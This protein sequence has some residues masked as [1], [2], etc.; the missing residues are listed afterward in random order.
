[1]TKAKGALIVKRAKVPRPQGG[2][3]IH[4][5]AVFH[6][7]LHHER[8]RS[9]RDGSEF[10]LVVLDVT[11][12][13]SNGRGIQQVARTIKEKMRSIDEVGWL[14][15]GNIGIL[16]PVTKNEGGRRFANRLCESIPTPPSSIPWMVYTYPAHWLPGS[17]ADIGAESGG[18]GH[19]DEKAIGNVF[20]KRVPVWK[21]SIDFIGSLILLFLF[22]P[23]FLLLVLYI[24]A[25]SPGKSFFRQQ[26]VGYRGKH[27]TFMKFRTMR[28]NT[29]ADAHRQYWKGLIK[30][31]KPMEK[32]DCGRDPRI[33]PGGKIIRKACLDELPQLF[34]VLRGDMSL[35][36]PRPCI[37]YEA[38]EYLRWHRH[39]FDILPGM[40]GLWQVSGKNK[41]SFEQ[42]VRLDISYAN[43]MSPLLD[44]K[45]LLL[46]IPAIIGMVFDAGLK[47]M[48]MNL[49]KPTTVG[50]SKGDEQ[51]FF[52][53]A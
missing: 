18:N 42:M 9:D 25:V 52:R 10:S 51:G 29:N 32:L 37:P 14:D 4:L 49:L 12:L 15:S 5:P 1:M 30:S 8:S 53:D 13:G 3:G 24:K 31:D 36:G 47:R 34:N 39:R 6:A 28:E 2:G 21:R 19:P 26:R 40:T 38:E 35:V 22:S 20:C 50:L 23:L 48:G 17:D 43:R 16:L 7:L 33:I 45:I 46:T 27:F 11:G 44:L 41:L